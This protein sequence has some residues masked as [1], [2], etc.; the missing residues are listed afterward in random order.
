MKNDISCEI[1]K[2]MFDKLA[3]K[4]DFLNN[5]ISLYTHKL[6]KKQAIKTLD[7]CENCKVLDLC[8]GS[9]DVS[10]IVKK[11]NPKAQIIGVDFSSKM[12]E[13][14]KNKIKNVEFIEAN[15]S[16]LPFSNDEFDI[17]IC[18]FGFRNIIEK[19]KALSEIKRV[20]KTNGQFLHID[21]EGKSK[22]S[23]IYDIAI[24]ILLQFFIKDKSPYKYLIN[25]KKHFYTTNELIEMFEKINLKC[26][27]KKRKF[28]NIVSFQ[29]M[30]K[31]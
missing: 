18:A 13:I 15:A 17:I 6:F 1:I 9:A 21:F 31:K 25:S 28:F 20:L 12:L 16:E 27:L 5:I 26:V 2:E 4:Y 30:I 8:C 11:I 24:L 23:L 3:Q 29:K 14:A 22:F 10:K 7:F 19:S